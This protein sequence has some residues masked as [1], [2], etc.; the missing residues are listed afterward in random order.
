MI[1]NGLI[2]GGVC[3]C[4]MSSDSS[5]HLKSLF[6]RYIEVSFPSL[7]SDSVASIMIW[8]VGLLSPENGCFRLSL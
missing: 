3:C 7:I 5:L 1:V 6:L 2:N 8:I 4:S